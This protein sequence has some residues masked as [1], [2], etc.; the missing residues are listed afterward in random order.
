MASTVRITPPRGARWRRADSPA[1]ARPWRGR[2]PPEQG[3]QLRRGVAAA[4]RG[5]AVGHRHGVEPEGPR[6]D[7]EG[8]RAQPAAPQVGY[9]D[10]AAGEPVAGPEEP[11]RRS[12]E[13]GGAPPGSRARRPRDLFRSGG[14]PGAAHDA[15]QSAGPRR[16]RAATGL[17]SRPTGTSRRPRRARPAHRRP[18]QV[19]QAGA[20]VEQR[21]RRCR[22][23]RRPARVR[24]P[25]RIA[26]APPN[27]RLARAMFRSEAA[28]RRRVGRRIVEQLGAD[29]AQASGSSDVTPR[30]A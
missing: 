9:H 22:V 7:P 26:A 19:A 5:H 17:R 30:A 27:H 12:S 21:E 18:R 11:D 16:R 14:D 6:A 4:D 2:R 10:G 25:R 13:P 8:E 3:T 1:A 24:R 29:G 23:A 28:D 15:R 20:E